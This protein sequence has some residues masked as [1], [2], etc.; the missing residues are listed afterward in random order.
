M[1]NQSP[2]LFVGASIADRLD[3]ARQICQSTCSP[4]QYRAALRNAALALGRALLEPSAEVPEMDL[5]ATMLRLARQYTSPALVMPLGQLAHS[6]LESKREQTALSNSVDQATQWAALLLDYPAT[7]PGGI[8]SECLLNLAGLLRASRDIPGRL[9]SFLD[10]P[11]MRPCLF[12]ADKVSDL[13]D[14][15]R[16]RLAAWLGP[17]I[18]HLTLP[19]SQNGHDQLSFAGRDVLVLEL[20]LDVTDPEGTALA[21]PLS[22]LLRQLVTDIGW[23][24]W[25]LWH[26]VVPQGCNPYSSFD[27]LMVR[28][29]RRFLESL[30]E[31]PPEQRPHLLNWIMPPPHIPLQ[32][33]RD[34]GAAFLGALLRLPFY[35]RHVMPELLSGHAGPL[36]E[37]AQSAS[38]DVLPGIS[39]GFACKHVDSPQGGTLLA[40]NHAD[41][42]SS[43]A[44]LLSSTF[45]EAN[46]TWNPG[47]ILVLVEMKECA[48]VWSFRDGLPSTKQLANEQPWVRTYVDESDTCLTVVRV[49]WHPDHQCPALFRHYE[50]TS[51]NT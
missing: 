43:S 25:I 15:C 7:P 29:A 23:T 49:Q 38:G 35:R 46:P 9:A 3:T 36:L 42:E 45:E 44:H 33:A 22:A 11:G 8:E 12:E 1:A 17:R 37:L 30:G 24:P 5:P 50:S 20:A 39:I 51:D 41:G 6:L 2:S 21:A 27:A 32:Q 10:P 19:G 48:F 14:F 31:L 34:W 13:V 18:G 4:L 26:L 28:G 40:G 16:N 47:D